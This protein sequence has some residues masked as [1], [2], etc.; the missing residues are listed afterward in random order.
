MLDLLTQPW[1]WYVAGP[2]IG[3]MVPLLLLLTGKSF[4]ISSSLRHLC[5][6][7][8]PGRAGYFRYDWRREGLWNLAFVL[9]ILL[10]GVIAGTVLHNPAPVAISEATRADLYALGIRHF[11]GLVPSDVFSWSALPT[12]RGLSALVLG[13]FLLGFGARYAGGCTSGHAIMGMA[14]FDRASIVA[15][16]GFFAGGL[17]VTYLLLPFLL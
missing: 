13:G 4:G 2:L 14:T 1:P 3:L 10:G 6:A 5:A 16:L 11:D 7:A 17:I 9:G 8:L 15:T 12:V